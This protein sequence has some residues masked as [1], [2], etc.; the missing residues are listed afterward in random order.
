MSNPHNP[1]QCAQEGV[2]YLL[3]V[4]GGR[5]S[6]LLLC[7]LL[8]AYGGRL[9]PNVRA[10]FANTGK[11][12][13]K[14]L[15][16]LREMERRWHVPIT[17]V[18]YVYRKEARG[19]MAD[20]KNTFRVVDYETA[21]RRGEPFE[22]LIRAHRMLPNAHKRMCTADLKV[23][24]AARFARAKLGWWRPR[25]HSIL[26]IRYDEPKRWAKAIWEQCRTV[27]PLVLD[28]V[29]EQDVKR[30]WAEQP[31][32]LGISRDLGNCDLCFMKG[33]WKLMRLITEYPERADWWIEQ[34]R[35]RQSV[36]RVVRKPELTRFLLRYTYED[37][38]AMQMI[39]FDELKQDRDAN[40]S[41]S[42]F[43]GD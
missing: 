41:V 27:Y 37:L 14:T 7:R 12:H 42:C 29:T 30:F 15:L 22:I 9:P 31:F 8:D 1:Y 24:T 20:P 43:C 18:E 25:P 28:K 10:V 40:E 32:D 33:R 39:P 4:S 6:G 13:E 26:G 38:R 35:Y 5:T 36:A 23:E 2:R 19:G 34:E 16:F 3:H 17:W 11:E 21:S